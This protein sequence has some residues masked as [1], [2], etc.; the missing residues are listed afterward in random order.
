MDSILRQLIPVHIIILFEIIAYS[1]QVAYP[2][3]TCRLKFVC[4]SYISRACYMLHLVLLEMIPH[5]LTSQHALILHIYIFNS[6][7]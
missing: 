5:L 6:V 1:C 4:I 2:L 7:W 3:Q